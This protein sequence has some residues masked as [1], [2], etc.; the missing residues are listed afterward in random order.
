MFLTGKNPSNLIFLSSTCLW[1]F[2]NPL[3]CHVVPFISSPVV[4]VVVFFLLWFDRL[5]CVF[6]PP[7][8]L[9]T[10]DLSDFETSV[11]SRCTTD[12][13]DSA[14]IGRRY[15]SLLPSFHH[16][17]P[18]P[19]LFHPLPRRK[20]GYI[21]GCNTHTKTFFSFFKCFPSSWFSLLN[22]WSAHLF[23]P[24][25]IRP[26]HLLVSVWLCLSDV[27]FYIHSF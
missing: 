1:S 7:P 13:A 12:S 2:P 11:D 14:F 9:L 17:P 15:W 10:F 6:P 4:A 26:P 20:Y 19:I 22:N 5:S 21:S 25:S 18:P 8:P 23:I 24:A 27:Y 3:L 16:F